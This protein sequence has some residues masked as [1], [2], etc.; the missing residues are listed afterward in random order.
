[1]PAAVALVAAAALAAWAASAAGHMT[2]AVAASRTAGQDAAARRNAAA[3]R[4]L[5][6]SFTIAVLP[7]T[8]NYSAERTAYFSRQVRW[9]LGKARA[10][11]IVFVSHVGDVVDDS[12]DRGQWRYASAALAPLLRQSELPFSIVRGNH[13][14]PVHF[15]SYI[16]LA[17][18]REKPWFVAA[19]P[20]GLSRA[21][22]FRVQGARFLHIGLECDPSATELAWADRL[23]R[24]PALE[25]LPVIVSTHDYLT[26]AVR[27]AAG[28]RI[29]KRF[30]RTHPMVFMVLCGHNYLE[31][32]IIS[33]NGA[34]QPVYQLLA[35]YQHRRNGGN[36]LLRLV[37]VDPVRG[38]IDVRTFSP[39]YEGRPAHHYETDRYSRFHYDLD[40]RERL[41]WRP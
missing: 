35:N 29:W 7:D 10:R 20:S 34:R 12:H 2:A 4:A 24:K 31:Y 17:T 32:A 9:V 22:T 16:P 36:G 6:R 25:G 26:L 23:L 30:V 28:E 41:A 39:Y 14:H 1:V 13:D 33:A 40:V 15:L 27:T 11:N 8:Q 19:S 5:T 37:T 38:R 21:Q 18:M 3:V